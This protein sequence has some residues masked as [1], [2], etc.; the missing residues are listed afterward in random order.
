MNIRYLY[1]YFTDI[2]ICKPI[3]P[4][5][6]KSWPP[7][8]LKVCKT[9]FVSHVLQNRYFKCK[10]NHGLFAPIEKI[11]LA[12]APRKSSTSSSLHSLSKLKTK[13]SS[14]RLDADL[15]TILKKSKPTSVT[16]DDQS[17]VSTPRKL[18]TADCQLDDNQKRLVQSINSNLEKINILKSD[19]EQKF[20][21]YNEQTS[22]SNKNFLAKS[23][24]R[25][26]STPQ[27][28]NL[29]LDRKGSAS[30]LIQTK[31]SQNDIHKNL[32]LS[33]QSK[34]LLNR[35]N[36]EKTLIT[37]SNNNN[38]NNTN[39]SANSLSNLKAMIS[40]TC[41]SSSSASSSSSVSSTNK[42]HEQPA[43]K[44]LLNLKSFQLKLAKFNGSS[45]SSTSTNTITTTTVNNSNATL[46]AKTSSLNV[47]KVNPV[48]YDS[49]S[50]GFANSDNN[51][52][53]ASANL[54]VVADQLA[55][56][57]QK[58]MTGM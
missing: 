7:P 15:E 27:K 52:S 19:L 17:T 56:Q 1:I 45:S 43:K 50:Y 58:E 14:D 34:M 33:Q 11:K 10:P 28:K 54:F 38:T 26:R 5:K 18:F 47:N 55:K 57:Q 6:D 39:S 31:S 48:E 12:S 37:N 53:E 40:S 30:S 25:S 13:L 22:N 2:Y 20:L 42:K 36:S 21:L 23:S 8:N 3:K 4:E 35:L 41:S 29:H 44:S 24:T 51:G 9:N 46:D 49:D 32:L 16:R